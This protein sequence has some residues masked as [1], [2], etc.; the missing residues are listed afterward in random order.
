MT[1]HALFEVPEVSPRDLVFEFNHRIANHL[2]S[3]TAILRRPRARWRR[4]RSISR[5][6]A[7]SGL[8]E[9]AAKIMAVSR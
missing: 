9:A 2:A 4:T 8:R 3:L 7:V 6:D 1:Q 5:K